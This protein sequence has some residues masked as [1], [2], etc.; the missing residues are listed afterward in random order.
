MFLFLHKKMHTDLL[1]LVNGSINK[2]FLAEIRKIL[3]IYAEPKIT[4]PFH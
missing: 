1:F 3:Q 4:E 2:Y